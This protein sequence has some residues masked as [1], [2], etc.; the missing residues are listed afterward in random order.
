MSGLKIYEFKKEG[1]EDDQMVV[2]QETDWTL[3]IKTD[4]FE[5]EELASRVRFEAKNVIRFLTK[6]N[7]DILYELQPN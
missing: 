7:R 6:E 5:P 3:P 4:D 2:L 1:P